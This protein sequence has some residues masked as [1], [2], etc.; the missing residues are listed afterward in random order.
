MAIITARDLVISAL[1]KAKVLALRDIPDNNEIEDGLDSLHMMLESWDLEALWPFTK[2]E[3]R[4]TFVTGQK[5]YT[6]GTQVGDDIQIPRI[7]KITG[8]GYLISGNVY[9]PMIELSMIAWSNSARVT[10]VTGL[11]THFIHYPDF[12]SARVE[13]YPEPVTPYDFILQYNSKITR[14]ALN[15]NIDLPSGYEAAIIYGLAVLVGEDNGLNVEAVKSEAIRF[16][17]VI[18]RANYQPRELS[19]RSRSGGRA[20]IR[21]D[22]IR[23][24]A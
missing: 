2:K 13:I 24:F 22:S 1:R 11:P 4:G 19:I 7:D 5:V 20:D 9:Q 16:K 21:S 8:F 15:D 18:K 3:F 14:Y 6:I 12:P 17:A 10:S 23:G